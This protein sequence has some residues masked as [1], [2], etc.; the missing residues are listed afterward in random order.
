M[1]PIYVPTSVAVAAGVL[2]LAMMWVTIAGVD[3]EK[4][5]QRVACMLKDGVMWQGKCFK[6]GS[7]IKL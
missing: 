1:K 3:A 2:L 6:R 7:E 5:E 4:G